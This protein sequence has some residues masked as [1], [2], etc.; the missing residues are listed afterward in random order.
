[1]R[2]GV[3]RVAYKVAG[4]AGLFAIGRRTLGHI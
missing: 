2:C 4:T 1:M 3:V